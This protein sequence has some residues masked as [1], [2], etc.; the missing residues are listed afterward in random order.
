M[1]NRAGGEVL[2]DP[3]ALAL[4]DEPLAGSVELVP[5]WSGW[6]AGKPACSFVHLSAHFWA[7]QLNSRLLDERR[8]ALGI[9]PQ[10]P[11]FIKGIVWI[12]THQRQ[13]VETIDDF[14]MRR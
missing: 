10:A 5:L 13:L 4:G 7:L 8:D 12:K 3:I 11:V 14:G 9:G 1:P 2:S 6:A